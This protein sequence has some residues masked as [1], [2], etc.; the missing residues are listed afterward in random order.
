MERRSFLLGLFALSAG[1]ATVAISGKADAAAL[2]A[3]APVLGATPAE[4][5]ATLP[6]GT[7]IEQAQYHRGPRHRRPRPRRQVCTVRRNRFGR[8]ERVCRWVY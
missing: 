7:P 6:D 4:K 3:A 8:R 2:G 5:A 1:A